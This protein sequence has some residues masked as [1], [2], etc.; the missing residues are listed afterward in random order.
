MAEDMN[1]SALIEEE[2]EK[3]KKKSG[4]N[5]G[6]HDS[7]NT[8]DR[9]GKSRRIWTLFMIACVPVIGVGIQYFRNAQISE[10]HVSVSK[11]VNMRA[12][13]SINRLIV[14]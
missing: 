12:T 2:E 9:S 7:G 3:K 6:D 14:G 1:K 10:R 11:F 4:N 8:E 13:G 5:D